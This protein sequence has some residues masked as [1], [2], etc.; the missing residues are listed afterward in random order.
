MFVLCVKVILGR[1]ECVQCSEQHEDVIC[2]IVHAVF[3]L[4]YI[5]SDSFSKHAQDV[6]Q[7]SQI[8]DAV[9]QR[10]SVKGFARSLRVCADMRSSDGHR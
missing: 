10:D 7:M 3:G 6:G 4:A 2:L 1:L 9:L 5:V 8:R